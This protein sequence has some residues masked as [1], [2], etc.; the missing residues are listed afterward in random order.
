M[1][2]DLASEAHAQILVL[3][4]VSAFIICACGIELVIS[5]RLIANRRLTWILS[6]GGI[7][8]LS[9]FGARFIAA[10]VDSFYGFGVGLFS[11]IVNVA[12]WAVMYWKFRTLRKRLANKEIS[13]TGRNNLGAA[14]DEIL[15]EMRSAKKRLSA[16]AAIRRKISPFS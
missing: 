8:L 1:F 15:D 13:Q 7:A 11:N 9:Y 16:F 2:F 10:W 5:S 12:F 3:R 14:F 4:L 6:N